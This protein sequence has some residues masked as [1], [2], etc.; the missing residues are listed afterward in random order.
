MP[1]QYQ[2]ITPYGIKNPYGINVGAAYSFG[3]PGSVIPTTAYIQSL[4]RSDQGGIL[5]TVSLIPG[6]SELL[7]KLGKWDFWWKAGGIVVGVA[8]VLVVIGGIIKSDLR[9]V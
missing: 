3:S 6:L 5:P 7:V 1:V 2:P 8:L 4:A 9:L